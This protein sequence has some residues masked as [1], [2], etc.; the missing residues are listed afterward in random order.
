MPRKKVIHL[1]DPADDEHTVC[2]RRLAKTDWTLAPSQV[3]CL[4]CRKV[5]K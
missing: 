4:A 3:T 5:M 1:N 2:G